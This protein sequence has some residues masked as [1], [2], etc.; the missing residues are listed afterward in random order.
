MKEYIDRIEV[1]QDILDG[2]IEISGEGAEFAQQAV[3][4]YR[5]VILKRLMV[6]PTEDVIPVEWIRK[7][8]DVFQS[9]LILWEREK[10]N[11]DD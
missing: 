4:G 1:M 5:S 3:E 2:E 6:Q 8:P 11:A 10:K 7:Q 9:L